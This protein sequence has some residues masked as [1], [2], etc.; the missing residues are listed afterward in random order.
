MEAPRCIGE[1]EKHNEGCGRRKGCMNV[2]N[3][4]M[5]TGRG[6]SGVDIEENLKIVLHEEDMEF[7]KGLDTIKAALSPEIGKKCIELKKNRKYNKEILLVA[8]IYTGFVITLAI[9]LW[10]YLLCGFNRM[11][12]YLLTAI[13]LVS[14][15]LLC[16]I[17]L[18]IKF[19]V[20]IFER[21]DYHN[22]I[23]EVR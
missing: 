23:K 21:G 4:D 20:N 16:C 3:D 8:F 1:T 19:S 5:L 7:I 12:V 6:K 17:P 10:N 14:A 13:G 2:A 11:H 18:L 22:E 9:F 15:V